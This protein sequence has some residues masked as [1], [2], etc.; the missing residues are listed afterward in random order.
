MTPKQLE[1]SWIVK[2][3][4]MTAFEIM[5]KGVYFQEIKEELQA[6]ISAYPEGATAFNR[7]FDMTFLEDYGINFPKLLACP[8][9]R[10][11]DILK[12]PPT[13]RM[14]QYRPDIKYKT[15]NCE[16]AYNYFFPEDSYVEKHRGADDAMHEAGIVW[17]LI[18]LKRKE[19]VSK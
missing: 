10:C 9:L 1:E 13:E 7:A 6:I 18:E 3:G 16:Q 8:M 11:V 17:K 4:Y 15:P 5:T 19:G 2:N 12:L 14:K